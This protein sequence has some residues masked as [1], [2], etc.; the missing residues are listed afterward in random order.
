MM[1]LENSIKFNTKLLK[2]KGC[3]NQE[4]HYCFFNNGNNIFRGTFSECSDFAFKNYGDYIIQTYDGM[5]V[6]VGDPDKNPSDK[7]LTVS[8]NYTVNVEEFYFNKAK[9][10]LFSADDYIILAAGA[11]CPVNTGTD[12]IAYLWEKLL[13]RTDFKGNRELFTLFLRVNRGDGT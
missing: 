12:Q 7:V 9:T 8:Q 6:Q 10:H 11:D 4:N 13:R 3:T 1:N 5:Q 2:I